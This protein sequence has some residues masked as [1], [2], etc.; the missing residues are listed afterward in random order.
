M[1]IVFCFIPFFYFLL[2][3]SLKPL[4]YKKLL[5]EWRQDLKM[6]NSSETMKEII[7]NV[8]KK[9]PFLKLKFNKKEKKIVK[10]FFI[11]CRKAMG[12]NDINLKGYKNFLSQIDIEKEYR[13]FFS[14]LDVEKKTILENFIFRYYIYTRLIYTASRFRD[15][16]F[17]VFVYL[18]HYEEI[19]LDLH[20]KHKVEKMIKNKQYFDAKKRNQIFQQLKKVISQYDRRI[21]D[22][23]YIAYTLMYVKGRMWLR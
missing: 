14:L 9:D 21:Y 5:T 7:W 2:S 4:P 15:Y 17:E 19:A 16:R 22:E 11:L 1:K 6:T 23:T 8:E 18:R 3:I 10:D 12:T 13:Q 20:I